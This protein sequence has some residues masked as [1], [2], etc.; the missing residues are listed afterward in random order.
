MKRETK[1]RALARSGAASVSDERLKQP[2]GGLAF[3][4]AFLLLLLYRLVHE[5]TEGG[6]AGRARPGGVKIDLQGLDRPQI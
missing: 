3:L 2:A 5:G 1:P 4:A 6:G